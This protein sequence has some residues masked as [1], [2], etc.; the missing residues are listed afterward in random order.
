MWTKKRIFIAYIIW[1][2][3]IIIVSIKHNRNYNI[4]LVISHLLL[5]LIT[6]YIVIT[7]IIVL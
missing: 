4:L 7:I 1:T 3:N 5:L 2:N 6:Y